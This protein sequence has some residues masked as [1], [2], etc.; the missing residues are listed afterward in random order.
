MYPWEE[1]F[2]ADSTFDFH[3]LGKLDPYDIERYLFEFIEDSYLKNDKRVLVITG[4]GR[5]VR[6]IVEK[7][8]KNHKYV[9]HFK[10]AG[11]FTGGMGAFEIDLIR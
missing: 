2:E 6:P 11:Y 10:T 4:K 1:N 8:L 9:K 5:V 7:L 3:L